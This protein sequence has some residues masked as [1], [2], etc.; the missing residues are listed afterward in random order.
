MRQAWLRL[1]RGPTVCGPGVS[2]LRWAESVYPARNMVSGICLY[3]P[4]SLYQKRSAFREM[5]KMHCSVS[6][7]RGRSPAKGETAFAKA[8]Q[9]GT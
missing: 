6:V 8:E 1:L 4:L 3:L 5:P 9:V 7:M 2:I